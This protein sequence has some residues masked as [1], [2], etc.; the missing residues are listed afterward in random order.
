MRY[1]WAYLYC[2]STVKHKKG[3]YV[4][5]HLCIYICMRFNRYIHM[6]W[7][8]NVNIILCFTF[9]IIIISLSDNFHVVD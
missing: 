9:H 6:F 7:L 4:N 1:I 5:I 8:I 2:Q 3:I